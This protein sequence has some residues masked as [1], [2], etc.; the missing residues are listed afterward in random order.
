MA[1]LKYKRQFIVLHWVLTLIFGPLFSP[2]INFVLRR[3]DE[4]LSFDLAEAYS[5]SLFFSL[6]FSLPTLVVYLVVY[7]FLSR[8]NVS[9]TV[10]KVALVST[11]IIGVLVSVTLLVGSSIGTEITLCYASSTLLSGILLSII[12]DASKV[13]V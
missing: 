13:P 7:Y 9:W 12:Y 2:W 10:I 5:I 11:A 3:Q 4:H 6:I 8:M 1:P